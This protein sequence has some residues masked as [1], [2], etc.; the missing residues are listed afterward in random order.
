MRK[1]KQTD[2]DGIYRR[3]DSPYWWVSLTDASGQRTRRSTGTTDRKEAEALLAKWRLET[4]RLKQWDEQ[5]SRTFDELMLRYLQVTAH[6]KRSAERDRYS[7]KRL[8][9]EFTERA[10]EELTPVDVR[11]YIDKRRAAGA[12]AGTINREIGLLSA[13]LNWARNELDWAIPNPA[14]RRRLKEP[15]GRLRWLTRAEAGALVR[16]AQSE[17][18]AP[19]LADFVRL[20]LH[21]GMRRGEM[22]GLEW[23]RVDLQARLIH[24]EATQTK[25]GKRRSVPIN[26][27][28]YAAILLRMRFRSQH[29]PGSP[30]VF[31]H[32]NGA[33]V[34]SIRRSFTTACRRADIEDFHIHDLRHTCAAWL[35]SA[36]VPLPEVRDLLGHATVKMTERYAHLAPENIRAAVAKLDNLSHDL[37]TLETQMPL[38]SGISN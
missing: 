19:Y 6:E 11:R 24:L 20:A 3:Q 1:R 13:A 5:P 12:K 10:I 22:L 8:Y 2:K 14:T 37:V 28:A 32:K 34:Q 30:W 4:H 25:N 7:A 29:C 26:A 36:G 21:T 33:R 38:K 17:P 23:C 15:E 18:Q 31:C 35:V 16:A 9:A 27:E